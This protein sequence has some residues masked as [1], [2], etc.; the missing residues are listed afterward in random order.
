VTLS[1]LAHRL[2]TDL[3]DRRRARAAYRR[4][5]ADLASYTS[6]A[7]VGDLL[8]ALEDHDTAE[9]AQMRTILAGNLAHRSRSAA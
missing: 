3:D 1:R 9:A 2:R 8:A 7:E 5:E 6:D 4:L